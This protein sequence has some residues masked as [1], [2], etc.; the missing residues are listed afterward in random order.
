MSIMKSRLSA[1]MAALLVLALSTGHVLAERRD[2]SYVKKNFR[3][4]NKTVVS[5]GEGR[6]LV[7]ELN[8]AD[9][10]YA[11]SD[12][13]IKEEWTYIQSNLTNGSGPERGFYIDLHEDGNQTYGSWEGTKTLTTKPDGSWELHWEGTYKYLGGTGR[14][15]NV[16]GGGKYKGSASP[17]DPAGT[18]R[19][20][21]SVDY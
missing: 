9:I 5:V 8:M 17:A 12:F 2:E 21:G 13:R 10:T 16:K 14:F 3:T 15:K 19:G 7:Q 20:S 6:E 18:E 4:A 11:N 1:S